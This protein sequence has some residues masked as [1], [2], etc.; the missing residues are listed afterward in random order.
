MSTV[1]V[2]NA[3][4]HSLKLRLLGPDDDD[5]GSW[6]V[7]APP[8]STEAAE[9]LDRALDEAD[10]VTAVGHR[11]VHGGDRLSDHALVDDDVRAALDAAA[12]L[13][14]LHVPP[15][16][17]ALDRCRERLPD[18]PQIACL[19]T[20]FHAGLPEAARTYAVPARWREELGV[21]RYGFHG[22][23][24][25]WA[26]PRAAELL[27]RDVADLQLVACHLGS[28]ASV[29][30][31][32]GGRSVWTSM[33][34]TPL[35]GL[36]MVT[37]SGTVDPGMITW[38]QTRHGLSATDVSDALEHESGLTALSG[39]LGGDT[40]DLVAAASDGNADAQLALDV[41]AL[42]LRQEVAVAA[43]SLDRL[44]AVVFTGEIGADQPEVREAVAAG[45]PVLGLREGLSTA[46]DVDAVVSPIGAQVPVVLVHPEEERQIAAEV[47][48]LI[49]R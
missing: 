31:V 41:F 19:D 42:R 2:V 40:R 26:V 43:A 32:A 38:L 6:T 47:R 34:F 46:Q 49:A 25:A 44:D 48:R 10:D 29:C 35:E 1:L 9:L 3:G 37:R 28:G 21:R 18:V 13:A 12:D 20:V 22:L 33:G 36:V 17:A 23:S 45:L 27:G 7:D 30:A 39:G 14:P 24:Y 11:V 8:D 5:L 15:A 4:G 16:L